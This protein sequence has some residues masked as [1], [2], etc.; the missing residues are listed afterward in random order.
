MKYNPNVTFCATTVSK[1]NLIIIIFENIKSSLQICTY[2]ILIP[3]VLFDLYFNVLFKMI[4]I[5][6]TT[7]FLNSK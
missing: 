5:S 4:L 7:W 2:F 3:H 6:K 1:Q